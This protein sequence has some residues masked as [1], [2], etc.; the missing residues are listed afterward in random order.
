MAELLGSAEPV[1]GCFASRDTPTRPE[2]WQLS[3]TGQEQGMAMGS[4]QS[5]I[6]VPLACH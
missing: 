6:A 2:R 5:K 3:R 1:R 4:G